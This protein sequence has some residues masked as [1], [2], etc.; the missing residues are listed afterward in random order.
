MLILFPVPE[1]RSSGRETGGRGGSQMGVPA[2]NSGDES[3]QV[4]E[5]AGV[6]LARE[7]R[8][9]H[10]CRV[11]AAVNQGRRGILVSSGCC[12]HRPGGL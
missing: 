1:I 9:C 5:K 4:A 10:C 6:E 8:V 7:R 12:D 2:Q 3:G 11:I